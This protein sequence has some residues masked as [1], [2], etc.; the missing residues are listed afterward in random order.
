MMGPSVTFYLQECKPP[1]VLPVEHAVDTALGV[2]RSTTTTEL[3][4]REHAW[5]TVR[6]YLVASVSLEDDEQMQMYFFRHP[7]Y[8]SLLVFYQETGVFIFLG[9]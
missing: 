8:G 7:T 3:F 9:L 1:V 2:L 4:Y 5:D 6:S